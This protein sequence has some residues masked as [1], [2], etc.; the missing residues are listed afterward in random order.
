MAGR[1]STPMRNVALLLA[2]IVAASALGSAVAFAP[3]SRAARSPVAALSMAPRFDKATEKWYT[4]DP[5]ERAGSSYGPIGSLYRAG[6]KPF[7]SRVFNPDTYDQ[8]V[9]KYMA[10]DGCDRKEAQGNMDAFLEN[11]QDWAY[12]KVCEQNGSYKKDYANANMGKKQVVLSTVWGV[13][14]TYFLGNLAY[15]GIQG[16]MMADSFHRTMELL[17]VEV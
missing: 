6:P 3:S 14:V 8:A 15:N 12:Q 13:G 1:S 10:Q 11:P 16:G 5:A 4:D 17:G 9:L 7:L 2:A